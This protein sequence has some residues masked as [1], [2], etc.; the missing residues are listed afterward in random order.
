MSNSIL[1]DRGEWHFG[2]F[3]A[4]GIWLR[5]GG[6]VLLHLRAAGTQHAGTWGI[7]GGAREPGETAVDAAVRELREESGID[8]PVRFGH[9][10]ID[11][12]GNWSYVTVAASCPEPLPVR[13]SAEGVAR[14]VPVRELPRLRMHPGLDKTWRGLP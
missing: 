9:S 7:P 3:G 4:A 2:R 8:T 6:L 10:H 13:R 12:H 5:C 1:C 14:W 11:D